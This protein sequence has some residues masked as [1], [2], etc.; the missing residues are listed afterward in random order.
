M[1][2]TNLADLEGRRDRVVAA[3][4]IASEQLTRCRAATITGRDVEDALVD[5]LDLEQAGDLLDHALD[6]Q[7]MADLLRDY[8]FEKL[9]PQLVCEIE[10]S[11]WIVPASVPILV[12]EAEAKLRGHKW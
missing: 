3:I 10:L 12:T 6:G 8:S 4:R 1:A 7:Q 5:L 9:H 11:E 2:L